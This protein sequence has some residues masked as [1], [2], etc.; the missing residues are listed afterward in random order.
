MV[1]KQFAQPFFNKSMCDLFHVGRSKWNYEFYSGLRDIKNRQV[2][3]ITELGWY[4]SSSYLESVA[5]VCSEIYEIYSAY[6]DSPDNIED[7]SIEII[8][9]MLRLFVLVD[10][11]EYQQPTPVTFEEVIFA[12]NPIDNR[13]ECLDTGHDSFEL[14]SWLLCL[15]NKTSQSFNSVRGLS[16]T[17][18]E[19]IS[20][21]SIFNQV[22]YMCLILVMKINNIDPVNAR[23]KDFEIVL[24]Y[25]ETK[26]KTNTLKLD[27]NYVANTNRHK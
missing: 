15:Y 25:F 4:E 16:I 20:L 18:T 5:L 14:E 26:L 23:I 10:R 9:V 13:F 3:L 1:N 19:M 12:S 7:Q 11:L 2:A 27:N 21:V 24:N 17:E 22:I 6:K 8:D